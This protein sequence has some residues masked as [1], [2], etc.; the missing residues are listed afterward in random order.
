MPEA[1]TSPCDVTGMYYFHG[2]C[3]AFKL[4]MIDTRQASSESFGAYHGIKITDDVRP[5]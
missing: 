3:L 2:N 1:K 5:K 4:N